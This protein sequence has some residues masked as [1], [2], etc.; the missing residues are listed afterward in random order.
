MN[1]RKQKLCGALIQTH[2]N[3]YFSISIAAVECSKI[4]KY[5]HKTPDIKILKNEIKQ[6]RR[7]KNK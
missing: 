3:M 7:S 5:A 4:E 6:W 1:T 2:T